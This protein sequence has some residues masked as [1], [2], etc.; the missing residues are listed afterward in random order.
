M[1]GSIE[2]IYARCVEEGD[3]WLWQGPLDDNGTPIMRL[4]G[5]RKLHSVRRHILQLNG[6]QLGALRATNTCNVQ[7]CVNP[8]HAVGWTMAQLIKR[9]ADTTGYARNPARNAKIAMKKR[10]HSP[11]TP[12]LIQEIRLSP[13]SGRAIAIRLGHCQAT[14]QAI[15]AHETWKDYSG[16]FAGLGAR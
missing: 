4:N 13:E 5:S 16:P 8:E 2:A 9:A 11:L 15:R 1:E 7:S 14:V 10:L 3:C 6:K 12:E